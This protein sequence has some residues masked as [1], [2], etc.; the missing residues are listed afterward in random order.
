MSWYGRG[1]SM[2]NLSPSP[3]SDRVPGGRIICFGSRL[4]NAAFLLLQRRIL[5]GSF[6]II[7]SALIGAD[8]LK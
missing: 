5:E 6:E 8:K 3:R 2:Q 1:R 7:I 4:W